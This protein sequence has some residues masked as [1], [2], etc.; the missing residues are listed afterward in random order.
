M[1]ENVTVAG[2]TYPEVDS[3]TMPTSNGGEA[4]FIDPN[5][6]GFVRYDTAQIL[7]NEEKLQAL[8]NIGAASIKS[9]IVM[10]LPVAN[11]APP[12]MKA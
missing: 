2:A 7:T 3:V 12:E 8:K 11:I 4:V 9:E 10:L 1:A 6:A 5:L